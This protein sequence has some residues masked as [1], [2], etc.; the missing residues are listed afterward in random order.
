[1]KQRSKHDGLELAG[2]GLM[3]HIITHSMLPKDELF[4]SV[5]AG[6]LY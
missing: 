3:G 5:L 2:E 6:F 4:C 1:M